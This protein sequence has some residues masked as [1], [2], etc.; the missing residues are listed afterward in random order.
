MKR[1]PS[2]QIRRFRAFEE[3]SIPKLADVNLFVGKNNTGKTSLLE[4]L[5]LYF[6]EGE[7]TKIADVLISRDEFA[8]RRT[9]TRRNLD[10]ASL[11]VE[12]LFHNRGS[13]TENSF[14]AV[15]PDSSFGRD[16]LIV[17]FVWLHETVLETDGSIRLQVANDLFSDTGTPDLVPGLRIEF[18]ERQLLVR[19]SR[20]GLRSNR[21]RSAQVFEPEPVTFL[22]STGLTPAE[23]GRLWDTVA[24]TED[25]ESIVAALRFITPTTERLVLVENPGSRTGERIMMVKLKTFDDPVPIRSL[26]E[27]INHLL[28]ICLALV[29]ARDG[30]LLIDEVENGL[31]YS[32]QPDLWRLILRQARDWN[33]QVFA[34]THSWDCVEGFQRAAS[35]NPRPEATLFRLEARDGY[36][37]AVSFSAS[38]IE[39]ASR[40]SIEVR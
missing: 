29:R 23:V 20:L 19:L 11:A 10:D 31:H 22:P 9:M 12:S 40:Q 6:S 4:A 38:E 13:V 5:R 27:G 18:G 16:S 14:F 32:V 26:G 25:E 15:G 39:V 2:L 37:R 34:T 8:L 1:L 35:E 28:G 36:A 24:L 21:V 17:S 33:I 30:V 7:R 3:L